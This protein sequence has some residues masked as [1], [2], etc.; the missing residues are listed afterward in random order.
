MGNHLRHPITS[1]VVERE[2]DELY[3]AA[4]V[5]MNGFRENMED[6]HCMVSNTKYGLF[7]V[8]DGHSGTQ[9]SAFC[10]EALPKEIAKATIPIP[11]NDIVDITLRVDDQFRENCKDSGCTACYFIAT[12]GPNEGEFSLQVANVGDSRIIFGRNG[13]AECLPMTVDHQ[14]SIPAEKERIERCGGSVAMDRV[15]GMLAMSRAMGDFEYKSG[16][17]GNLEQKVIAKPDITHV[18][19]T[20]ADWVLVACDGV[21]ESDFKNEEVVEFVKPLMETTEDIAMVCAAVCDEALRRGSTDNITCMIVQFKDGREFKKKGNE[22]IP[23]PYQPT[24]DNFKKAYKYMAEKAGLTMGQA[25]EMRYDMIRNMMTE[26]ITAIRASG[27]SQ[28][29]D[30]ELK[31]LQEELA[32]FKPGPMK[33]E[34]A[35]RTKWFEE[36]SEKTEPA[37]D[38][39]AGGAMGLDAETLER[40]KERLGSAG[41]AGLANFL[42]MMGAEQ[43]EEGLQTLQGAP[44][45]EGGRGQPKPQAKNKRKKGK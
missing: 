7:G 16:P 19:C 20:K 1:K 10:A 36:L 21:F 28:G 25:I 31:S 33:L 14:P 6:S 40:I 13:G 34:G 30:E 41:P 43:E 9:C 42:G 24:K 35:A 11:D 4:V 12:P 15:D 38:D 45:S 27:G 8:F 29:Q 39:G 2:G 22:F 32:Y 37:D 44:S 17:G 26:R 18:V 23:G 3:T 5:A